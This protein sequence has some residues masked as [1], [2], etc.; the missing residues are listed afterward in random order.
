MGYRIDGH[1]FQREDE[2]DRYL[3]LKEMKAKGHIADFKVVTR[4][5]VLVHPYHKC[6]KCH[7]VSDTAGCKKCGGK[8]FFSSG[9]Q[10]HPTFIVHEADGEVVVEDVMK[11]LQFSHVWNM[12]KILYDLTYTM[13]MY[14]IVN[15]QRHRKTVNG[16]VVA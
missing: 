5:C 4:P 10:Y 11:S 9:I 7:E 13:P 16:W 8:T 12:K 14:V 6:T 1:Q 15:G 2:V 3:E